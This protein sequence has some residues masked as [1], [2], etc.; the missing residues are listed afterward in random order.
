M[1]SK[2]LM[3]LDNTANISLSNVQGVDN[4]TRKV[5]TNAISSQNSL[6]NKFC[7]ELKKYVKVSEAGIGSLGKPILPHPSIWQQ[8]YNNKNNK[9]L[10]TRVQ[11]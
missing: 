1:V 6:P 2:K 7:E 9:Y 8:H 10:K 5:K 11:S 3:T 4:H